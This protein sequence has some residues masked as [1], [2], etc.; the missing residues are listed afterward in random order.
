MYQR[1]S[2]VEQLLVIIELRF[3]TEP[4]A[5]VKNEELTLAVAGLTRSSDEQS[6]TG[7]QR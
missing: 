6:S 4:M 2:E 7:N 5:S 3:N 1:R